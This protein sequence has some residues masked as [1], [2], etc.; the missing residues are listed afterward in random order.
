MPGCLAAPPLWRFAAAAGCVKRAGGFGL[1][2]NW[3]IETQNRLRRARL[4]AIYWG[5][6]S[7]RLRPVRVLRRTALAVVDERVSLVAAG[8]AYYAT[9]ALFPA[10]SMLIAIYGMAFDPKTVEPQL[11]VLKNL[12]APSA[13]HLIADS[14]RVLVSKPRGTLTFGLLVSTGITVWSASAAT[15][16]ILGALNLAY[17]IRESRGFW[18][19]HAT[20]LALT[21]GVIGSAALVLALLVLVPAGISF[22]GFAYHTR[23]SVKLISQAALFIFVLAGFQVL[24]R[25]GPSRRP[26]A[27]RLVLPGAFAATLLWAGASWLFT[28]YIGHLASLDATYGPMAALVG[29]LLGFYVS[30]FVLLAGAAMNA[31]IEDEARLAAAEPPP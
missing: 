31:A 28:Y 26:A 2:S 25:Y 20:A 4:R 15:R 17:G 30:A 1:A 24:Y 6:V 21:L 22:L 23:H 29:I 13:F 3:V 18:H 9:L 7:M 5:R 8:C 11:Q 27:R 14:V 19:F 12:L 16:S 10:I